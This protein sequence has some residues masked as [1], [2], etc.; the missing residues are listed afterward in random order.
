MRAR[1]SP[2]RESLVRVADALRPLLPELVFLGGSVAE[3]LITDPAASRIR[4]TDDVDVIVEV[5]T[6]SQ[7]ERVGARLGAL[8]F[9]RDSGPGAPICRWLAP[10][11][12][13]QRAKV[14]VMPT[15]ETPMGPTNPW[16]KVAMETATWYALEED[17]AIRLV[18]APAFI[19]TKWAAFQGRGRGDVL[20]SHDVEDI[21]TVVAGRPSVAEEM[22]KAPEKLRRFVADCTKEF[23]SRDDAH[24]AIE[25]A[26]PDA[27]LISGLG[28]R[29]HS[30]LSLLSGG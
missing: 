5:T 23:L 6:Y 30:R 18:T 15:A 12:D 9:S 26:L 24:D 13:G 2:N 19:A 8:G 21:I 22:L 20:M 16:Y 28:S 4:E 3:L 27:R 17:L 1:R 14:D 25:D 11:R 29:V 7:Y 10:P